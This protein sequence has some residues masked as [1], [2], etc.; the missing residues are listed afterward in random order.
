MV[1]LV[2]LFNCILIW[3]ERFQVFFFFPP[4]NVILSKIASTLLYKTLLVLLPMF[5]ISYQPFKMYRMKGWLTFLLNFKLFIY[6]FS[7][8]FFHL[9]LQNFQPPNYIVKKKKKVEYVL[10]P[11]ACCLVEKKFFLFW[12]YKIA[13]FNNLLI[14]IWYP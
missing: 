9:V 5:P 11:L 7:L 2:L 12:W 1:H 14:F 8:L 3:L 4:F 13:L 10:F 6:Y